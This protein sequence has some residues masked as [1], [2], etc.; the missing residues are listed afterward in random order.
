MPS[1]LFDYPQYVAAL[2]DLGFGDPGVPEN[3]LRLLFFAGGIG[4]YVRRKDGQESYLQFY[5]RRDDSE[6]YSKGQLTMHNSLCY[7][8]NVP[9]A[10]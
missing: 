1:Q 8:W 3:L 7:A 4:N 10:T 5:H 6:I 2:K 9:F